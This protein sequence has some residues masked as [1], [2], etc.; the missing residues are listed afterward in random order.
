MFHKLYRKG[1]REKARLFCAPAAQYFM[2]NKSLIITCTKNNNTNLVNILPM[3][4]EQSWSFKIRRSVFLNLYTRQ[5]P[6]AESIKFWKGRSGSKYIQEVLIQ[7]FNDLVS[8][9]NKWSNRELRM[10]VSKIFF[11]FTLD[12]F[13]FIHSSYS[14]SS[15]HPAA[16]VTR[17]TQDIFS[18]GWD[19][20]YTTGWA[21]WQEKKIA[22]L[23]SGH[24]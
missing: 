19:L 3:P 1:S 7:I 11:F 6:D 20:V 18:G 15:S 4:D 22:A 13:P 14:A 17:N 2:K 12:L 21:N 23:F 8:T 5:S 24:A 16:L 10:R 9:R